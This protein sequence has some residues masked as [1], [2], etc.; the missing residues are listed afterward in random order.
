MRN[1]T[2]AERYFGLRKIIEAGDRFEWEYNGCTVKSI[3]GYQGWDHSCKCGDCDTGSD[4]FQKQFE[5][6]MEDQ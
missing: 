4:D 1:A 5:H 2:L 6:M 3:M